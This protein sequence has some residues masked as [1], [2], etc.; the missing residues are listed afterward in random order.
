MGT[1]LEGRWTVEGELSNRQPRRVLAASDGLGRQ[2]EVHLLEATAAEDERGRFATEAALLERTSHESVLSAVGAGGLPDGTLYAVYAERSAVRLSDYAAVPLPPHVIASLGVSLLSA[3]AHVH[4][5]DWRVGWLSSESVDVHA[6]DDELVARIVRLPGACAE[7]EPVPTP[8]PRTHAAPAIRKGGVAT[9]ATD[10]FAFGSLL[11]ALE[12]AD[13]DGIL[14]LRDA[15]ARLMSDAVGGFAT[16][17]EA[18]AA[19]EGIV[20]ATVPRPIDPVAAQSEQRFRDSDFQLVTI[21]PPGGPGAAVVGSAAVSSPALGT[22]VESA[23]SRAWRWLVP[24]AL[25]G[26]A[27][28]VALTMRPSSSTQ[29][30]APEP[31]VAAATVAPSSPT[32]RDA[33]PQAAPAA[34]LGMSNPISAVA[35]LNET[36]LERVLPFVDR[37]ALIDQ[38]STRPDLWSR[39]DA[40]WNRLLDLRQAAAAPRPCTTFRDA[41]VE[42]QQPPATE[43]EWALLASVQVP[44]PATVLGAGAPP[45]ESCEGLAEEFAQRTARPDTVA[46]DAPE[47]ASPGPKSRRGRSKKRRPSAPA[48]ATP[49]AAA[50]EPE[51]PPAPVPPK[52]VPPKKTPSVAERLDDGIKSVDF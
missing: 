12:I 23:P 10:L 4:G 13:S 25:I 33:A 52:K 30:E 15:I 36:D 39:V 48:S 28:A 24:L 8:A 1:V 47:V 21:A 41:L 31:S 42:L 32:D 43:A 18:V 45:D 16:A 40:R 34:P 7:G 29:D 11:G 3:A 2:F 46:A 5:L 19:F 17:G 22:S 20:A 26:A 6:R 14:P 37:H 27:A 44:S 35:R 51:A 50:S 49:P 38:L 9:I